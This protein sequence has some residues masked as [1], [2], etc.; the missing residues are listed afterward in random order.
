MKVFYCL[1][2]T[3]ISLHAGFIKEFS[4]NSKVVVVHGKEATDEEKDV[5]NYIFKVLELDQT[6]DLYDHIID[7][8]Y[9]LKHKYF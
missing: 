4:K 5:A 2:L 8:A 9:A 6:G 1:L 7:D 3:L